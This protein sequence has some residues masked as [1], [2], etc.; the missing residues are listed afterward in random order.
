MDLSESVYPLRNKWRILCWVMTDPAK[1][2]DTAIARELW[3]SKC[4]L[5]LYMA[6][7]AN[8]S[9]PTI[10]LDMPI[11]RAHTSMKSRKSWEYI[12][13]HHLNDFD[14]F[15]KADP[16]TF[17]VVENLRDYLDKR[18]PNVSEYYGHGYHPPD[19]KFTYM[20]GGPGVVL[21]RAAVKDFNEKALQ[22][23][24]NTDCIVDGLGEYCN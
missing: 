12:Y 18:D 14:F 2:A 4:D 5:G 9:F 1:L 6:S 19:W 7:V 24:Q 11:G 15:V 10:G 13:K 20:A 17:I 21:S 3:V 16:D 22:V 23:E 8:A